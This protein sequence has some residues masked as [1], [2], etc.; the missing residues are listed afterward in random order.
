MN[1]KLL[2]EVKGLHWLVAKLIMKSM[3]FLYKTIVQKIIKENIL[4]T[5]TT[6]KKNKI[7]NKEQT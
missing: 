3:H 2:K 5:I 4:F 1:L 7:P 6:L